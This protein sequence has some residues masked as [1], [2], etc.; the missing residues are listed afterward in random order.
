MCAS[1]TGVITY[2]WIQGWDLPFPDFNT[3]HKCRNF[4]EVLD[5]SEKNRVHVPKERLTRMGY[6]IDLSEP[7]K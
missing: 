4:D 7:P 6:E 3:W 5:W 2:D 1:D